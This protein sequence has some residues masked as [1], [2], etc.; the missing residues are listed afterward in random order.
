[1]N[2]QSEARRPLWKRSY[3][4]SDVRWGVAALLLF[5]LYV[6]LVPTKHV[7]TQAEI[8][9]VYHNLLF[10]LPRWNYYDLNRFLQ[11]LVLSFAAVVVVLSPEVRRRWVGAW[12]LLPAAGRWGLLGLLGLG[13]VSSAVAASPRHGFL[14]VSHFVLLFTM[15]GLVVAMYRKHPDRAPRWLL[16]TAG[17]SV[18]AYLL[19]FVFGYVLFRLEVVSGVWPKRFTGLTHIRFVNQFQSWTLPLLPACAMAIPSR[20]RWLRSLAVLGIGLW[21]ALAIASEGRGTLLS[22]A[23]AL[24]GVAV[25]FR[26]GAGRYLAIQAIAL[27]LG[28]GMYYGLF[29]TLPEARSVSD[30]FGVQPKRQQI[31]P[32]PAPVEAEG[33]GGVGVAAEEP[34]PLNEKLELAMP[35]VLE[36]FTRVTESDR[37]QMWRRALGLAGRYPVLGAGPMHYAWPP[38]HFAV[39]AHPHNALFQIFGEWGIPAGLLVVGLTLWGGARWWGWERRRVREQRGSGG[40]NADG[41]LGVSLV[42][43]SIAAGSHAMLSGLIV[44][45]YSQ[46][47]LVLFAGWVWARYAHGR[48]AAGLPSPLPRLGPGRRVALIALLLASVASVGYSL[49]DA[50]SFGERTAKFKMAVERYV[51]SPRYWQQGYFGVRDPEVI[52]R[53]KRRW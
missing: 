27:V 22:V 14:E 52:E 46:M 20:R 29:H 30:H 1:M 25:V 50:W 51:I 41:V 10:F 19:Q 18:L 9:R 45:P 17:V 2:E 49:R 31:A 33:E 34:A 15:A 44:M 48:G 23:V 16:A 40:V 39:T 43:V 5:A 35:T 37:P 6:A 4:L 38:Y 8:Y 32:A 11:I 28:V 36:R 47:H 42:A 13:A 7:I 12:R 3:R 53:A 21:W 26:R 24:V